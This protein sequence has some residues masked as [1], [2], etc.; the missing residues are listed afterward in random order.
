MHFFAIF[1]AL[2]TI[3]FFFFAGGS[4]PA[5]IGSGPARVASVRWRVLGMRWHTLG[6]CWRVGGPPR[7][8]PAR[9]S[10]NE[11]VFRMVDQ[12]GR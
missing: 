8:P 11:V 4:G 9:G 7:L 2:H 10:S 12:I 3:F 5:W 1:Q 6:M